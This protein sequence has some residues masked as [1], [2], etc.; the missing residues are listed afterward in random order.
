MTLQIEFKRHN[1][2]NFWLNIDKEYELTFCKA[3][4][5]ILP[6][7]NTELVGKAFYMLF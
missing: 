4:K 6:F 2:I 7:T 5:L 1:L 3:L